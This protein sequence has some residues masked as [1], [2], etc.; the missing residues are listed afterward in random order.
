[1]SDSSIIYFGPEPWEGMW[2]NRHHLLWRLSK[3]H[4]ILYVEPPLGLKALRAQLKKQE[5]S[6]SEIFKSCRDNPV[7]E[8]KSNL[9]VMAAPLCAPL[10]GRFGLR[11]VTR[12]RW[13]RVIAKAVAA[14]GLK[15][16]DVWLSRP[17]MV[18]LIGQFDESTL[19]YHVVD[20]YLS[21][22]GVN[23]RN[24]EIKKRAE[25]E[26]LSKAH[27]VIVVSENLYKS[28]SPLNANTLLLPN[29]VDYEA[30]NEASLRPRIPPELEVLD[31]PILGYSGLIS[32]RL[33]LA[34]L[35]ELSDR[36]SECNLVF[37]GQISP[38]GCESELEL[39]K[40]KPNV[41]FLGV[42]PIDQVP[43]FVNG[44][45]VCLVPY[46]DTKETDNLSPLKL[47]DYMALGK[48]IV[49]TRF[50][51]AMPF[52]DHVYLAKS[53]GEFA[54]LITDALAEC[55]TDRVQAR[56]NIAKA[57]S[58]DERVAK[59]MTFLNPQLATKEGV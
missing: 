58:W 14:L 18:S 57:N 34:M 48:P 50:P 29:A 17:D 22:S 30:Y 40:S 4:K 47:Y 46:R 44:F 56:K 39:L 27:R 11:G 19:T 45:D 35:S 49:T 54:S 21:Y 55:A 52:T 32:G 33:D 6:W 16:L 5:V 10:S 28:K 24:Y 37:M 20:E 2:R 59:L 12:K 25:E 43:H 31:G 3:K 26:I 13:H 41:R 7:S 38:A 15:N 9:Y 1:M 53:R 36:F 51:A 23:S 42:R 8:V